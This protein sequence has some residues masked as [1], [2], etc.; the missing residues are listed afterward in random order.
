MP[1]GKPSPVKK[2]SVDT[3]GGT[4]PLVTQIGSLTI[5][6][7]TMDITVNKNQ[8]MSLEPGAYGVLFVK[9]NATLILSD[10]TYTFQSIQ[11]QS[12]GTIELDLSGAGLIIEVAAFVNL[13]K[14]SM[15][16]NGGTPE[17]ILWVINGT[18]VQLGKDGEYLGTFIAPQAAIEVAIGAHVTGALYGQEII[19]KPDSQ[20]DYAPAL[21]PFIERFVQ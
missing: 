8:T 4:L 9:K 11:V 6:P 18:S 16:M 15:M 7:G 2:P 20:V 17:E 3:S 5:T 14:N 10:G 12:G 1:A 13:Q 21:A 19:L